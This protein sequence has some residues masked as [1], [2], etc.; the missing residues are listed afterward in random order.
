MLYEYVLMPN[1]FHAIIEIKYDSEYSLGE[2]IGAFKSMTTKEY[3]VGVRD[4]D[5][6]PFE[7]RLWQRNYYE[8][9]I[10]DE[11]SYLKLSKIIQENGKMICFSCKDS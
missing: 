1:H 9:V 6:L 5:R 7:K 11:K 4:R 3:I 8:H 10:R 2:I